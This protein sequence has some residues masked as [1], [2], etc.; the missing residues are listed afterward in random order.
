MSPKIV[1][2]G[3]GPSHSVSNFSGWIN[4]GRPAEREVIMEK[5]RH[6]SDG[7]WT[8]RD[9]LTALIMAGADDEKVLAEAGYRP[10]MTMGALPGIEL[11]LYRRVT[12]HPDDGLP[13]YVVETSGPDAYGYMT[14][15]TWPDALGLLAKYAPLIG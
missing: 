15:G 4:G 10:C 6:Y 2:V 3:R 9:D 1:Y 7:T 5:I 12:D 14:A 13:G 8:D 11:H